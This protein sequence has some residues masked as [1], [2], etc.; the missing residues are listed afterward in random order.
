MRG[1]DRDD[2]AAGTPA[3]DNGAG[4]LAAADVDAMRWRRRW[5]SVKPPI[6]PTS[7]SSDEELS[8][9]ADG[10]DDALRPG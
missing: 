8:E 10:F 2:E 4:A 1:R 9:V 6:S 7:E 5:A 3:D